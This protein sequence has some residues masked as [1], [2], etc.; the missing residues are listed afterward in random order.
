MIAIEACY[1]QLNKKHGAITALSQKYDISRQF[2]YN[3][4]YMLQISLIIFASTLEE[5]R[6]KKRESV[7]WILA[8]RFE[9]KCSIG[10]ISTI[11]KQMSPLYSSEGYISQILKEIGAILPQNQKIESEKK[12]SIPMVS[13]EI[14]V[15]LLHLP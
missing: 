8:L 15:A 10:A 6:N 11:M 7:E 5:E 3:L 1:A 14:F 12:L 13:D 4:L 9:G 2:V